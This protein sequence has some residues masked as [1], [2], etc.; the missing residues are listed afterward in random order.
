MQYR[1][2]A[3]DL[4]EATVATNKFHVSEALVK[5][6]KNCTGMSGLSLAETDE[7][8]FPEV[9]QLSSCLASGEP[10]TCMRLKF[11]MMSG[12]TP[13]L[14]AL[15]RMRPRLADLDLPPPPDI[16][17]NSNW[18]VK[19]QNWNFPF[20]SSFLFSSSDPFCLSVPLIHSP[21]RDLHPSFSLSVVFFIQFDFY[22][23]VGARSAAVA[24]GKKESQRGTEGPADKSIGN[25]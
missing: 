9:R 17:Q 3:A 22:L 20:F 16:P 19:S 15:S 1:S 2:A 5:H 10:I 6:E 13:A 11:L 8:M 14:F 23:E 24:N 7:L 4:A 21:L 25:R 18:L 12:P